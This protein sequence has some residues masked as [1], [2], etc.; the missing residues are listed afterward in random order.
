MIA[1]SNNKNFNAVIVH[2]LDRFARN[3]YDS[4]YYKRKLKING[5]SVMS[6]TE[7]LDN[8]PESIIMES[9]LEGM[10]EYYSKNLAREVMKGMKETAYQC[11]H[12]GGY[13]PLGYDVD[14]TTKKYVINENEA[15]IV[16]LIFELYNKGYGYK[17]IL[18]ELQEKGY[19]TKFGNDF[20]QSSIR[21]ILTNEKYTGVYIFNQKKEKADNNKRNAKRKS[22]EEIIR[23]EDGMPAIIGKATFNKAMYNLEKHTNNGGKNSAVEKYLLS[24]LNILLLWW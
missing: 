3:R 13:A 22:E 10:S 16:R 11:K 6:V 2:K 4:A 19:K 8:S 5:V 9:M 21:G 18:A 23:I 15:K 7:K 12:N 20:S 24:G 17:K 1:D 14:P